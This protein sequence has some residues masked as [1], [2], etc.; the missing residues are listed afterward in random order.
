MCIY[1]DVLSLIK[2]MTLNIGVSLNNA[3]RPIWQQLRRWSQII[4]II[5]SSRRITI[6]NT[7][8]QHTTRT[9]YFFFLNVQFLPFDRFLYIGYIQWNKKSFLARNHF[10]VNFINS[11]SLLRLYYNE[12]PHNKHAVFICVV[13]DSDRNAR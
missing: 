8:I 5:L 9:L 7:I 2:P 1:F 6:T 13:D 11:T 3:I 12:E 10:V 4:L